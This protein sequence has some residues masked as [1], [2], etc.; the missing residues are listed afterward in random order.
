MRGTWI[1]FIFS[2]LTLA[3]IAQDG[4]YLT[5]ELQPGE[6]A[7]AFLE[8]HGLDRSKANLEQFK[9][10]NDLADLTLY[11]DT[12]YQLPIKVY[13]YNGKS[14]RTTIG[15]SDYDL[16]VKIQQ[17]NEGLVTSGV[18][19]K[20]YRDDLVLWVPDVIPSTEK[21][22]KATATNTTASSRGIFPI[23]GKEY[24][25]VDILS[26]KLTGHVYY[27]VAGHGG[28]DP[29][30]VITY[31]GHQLCEDEYAY[32]ISLRL[33]RNLLQHNATVYMI[34]RDENDGI[35][36]EAYLAHDKD[37]VC[38]PNRV[39]PLNQ[40]R[41]LNQRVDVIN[42][43]YK[44]HKAEG[45]KKQ[46]AI[47][48]HVDSRGQ[49][50]RIDMFFYHSPKSKKGLDMA[51]TLRNTIKAKYDMH[52]RGRGYSGTVKA[53]NLHMLRETHPVAVYA[54]LGNIRNLQDQKRFIIED[55]RQAVANWLCEGILNDN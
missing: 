55:N 16:A 37:E 38:Y 4:N 53:R 31:K 2:L 1:V 10:I 39:I 54:E 24:E 47:I 20:D 52:Q 27:V 26:T 51:T 18:K 49:G 9:E 35:R 45:A 46:R 34:I 13:S 41:R 8:R 32:D 36:G 22:E 14:I 12:P 29:G 42:A 19:P 30:A 11:K 25:Q 48:I 15:I 17:F 21:P 7:Y 3:G 23:F 44:K 40:V 33:A 50:Q 6:G 5:G 28:P 43:L